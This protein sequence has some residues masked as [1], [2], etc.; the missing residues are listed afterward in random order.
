MAKSYYAMS[1]AELLGWSGAFSQNLSATPVAFHVTVEQAT[2]YAALNTAFATALA[3]WRDNSTRTPVASGKKQ[4]ARE[5][6][7][8]SLRS[9]VPFINNNPLTT[10]AQRD[11]L[12][13]S[14]R[15]QPTP[16]PAP[17]TSP[18]VEIESVDRR[19]VK[20]RLRGDAGR[21]ARPDGVGGASVFS[22]VGPVAPTE[23]AQWKF[24][25]LISRTQFELTFPEPQTA[26]TA[27]VCANWYNERGETGPACNPV[28]VNLPASA[29]LPMGQS[30][31]IAA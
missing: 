20:I 11:A 1:D 31:K 29:V 4:A 28:S 3:V 5:A 26:A 19:T 12:G 25:G 22:F 30:L 14:A 23:P 24:E 8:D 27:W 2:A 18:I 15:K 13:I 21:R 7:V 16:I 10:D 9:L 6:L 17:S